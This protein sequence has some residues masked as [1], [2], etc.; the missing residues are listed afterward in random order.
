MDDAPCVKVNND[1][2]VDM[3]LVCRK[4]VYPYTPYFPY[5]RTGILGLQ[6]LL[7]Y[8]FNYYC[9]LNTIF[10]SDFAL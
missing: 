6:V 1:A 8:I 7:V 5:V 2:L 10:H 4:L 3:T 9:P